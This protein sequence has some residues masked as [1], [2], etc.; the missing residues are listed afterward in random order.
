MRITNLEIA[1]FK[2]IKNAF[3]TFPKDARVVC[4]IGAGD[5]TKSTI[6]QAIE[7]I[8]WPSWN[9]SASDSDFFECDTSSSIVLRGT[10]TELPEKLLS[11]DKFGLY[12]RKA[13]VPLKEG[14]NDEPVDG[15]TICLT[16]QLTIDGSLEPKWEV[17]C[18]RNEPKSISLSDRKSIIADKIGNNCAK[19]MLWGKYSVLQ[20]YADSKGTI[21]D[22]QTSVLRDIAKK[23]DLH[24]LDDISETIKT[25]GKEYGVGFK[26]DVTNH[27]QIQGI[28]LSTTVGLFDGK[29]PLSQRGLGSQRLL[30]MGLN[31][32]ASSNSSILLVD[33]IETGLEPYRLRSIINEF[34]LKHTT[35]GQVIMTTHSPIAVA[36]CTIKELLIV[37]SVNGTTKCIPLE[38]GDKQTDDAMQAQIRKNAEAVLCKRIIV[39]EGKTEQGFI[40]ALDS[41]LSKEKGIR[42]AFTGIGTADG[43]GSSAIKCT[44]Q[45]SSCGYDVCLFMDSDKADEKDQKEE[46]KSA[47]ISIFDW[48][49]PNA[50][51]EQIFNDVPLRLTTKLI[52]I[53][54]DEYGL[55]SVKSRL[56]KIPCVENDGYLVFNEMDASLKRSIG[57][58]AKTKKVEWYKRI[59]LGEALGN[60]IFSEIDSID[61][62]SKLHKVIDDIIDWVIRDDK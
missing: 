31:I 17:V 55:D 19:D 45:L 37:H 7:W 4:L 28:S 32:N 54:I 18:N 12:L 61:V 23:A 27:M 58:I 11:E 51:E 57:T 13:D 25:V 36:E 41:Y 26:G 29:A 60:V 24:T 50:I 9:L 43:G 1:N 30:S 2:G 20:K 22:V 16:I 34:R 39:C 38:S 47:G 33:E 14:E 59:D 56:S 3:I 10:F 8:L 48:E 44:K 53:A 35:A 15:S 42:I 6:L 21:H 5:S 40:R 49:E 62:N 52:A 46:L